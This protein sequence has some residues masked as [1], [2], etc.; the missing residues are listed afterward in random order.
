MRSLSSPSS[1]LSS[2][3]GELRLRFLLVFVFIT[4]AWAALEEAF[5]ILGERGDGVRPFR[6]VDLPAADA[7]VP[8]V[9][10]LLLRPRAEDV[11]A[12]DLGAESG[13]EAADRL[14]VLFT[15]GIRKGLAFEGDED[16]DFFPA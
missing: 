10:L 13:V 9:C 16:F 4:T 5:E 14:G 3:E 2:C 1:R 15:S 12:R 11:V 6:C 8:T 7:D